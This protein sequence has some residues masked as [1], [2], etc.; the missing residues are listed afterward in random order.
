MLDIVKRF[1]KIAFREWTLFYTDSL[2]VLLLVVASLIYA[3]YYPL[4]YMKEI[5]EKV[6]AGI[7]DLDRTAFSRELIRMADATQDISVYKVYNTSEEARDDLA[8]EKIYGY[9]EIPKGYESEVR[10]GSNVTLG[11]YGHGAFLMLYRNVATA[12]STVALT[13]GA[14]VK[15]KRLVARG[16]SLAEAQAIRDPIPVR[17]YNMFNGING[18]GAYVVPAVLMLVLQQSL[19]IGISILG[20][21]RKNRHFKSLRGRDQHEDA[22]FFLRYFGRS[23]AYLV[24]YF[25][26][27]TIYHFGIYNIFGFPQRG[28][29][30]TLFAFGLAFFGAVVNMGMWTAQFFERRETGMQIFLCLSIPF[31]FMSGFSWPRSYM[32]EWIQILGAFIPTTYAIPA[33]LALENMG[34]SLKDVWH[35]IIDLYLLGGFYLILG[36]TIGKRHDFIRHVWEQRGSQRLAE[37]LKKFHPFS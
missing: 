34:A 11:V 1:F 31:L 12:F 8:G 18:Y 4:P 30:F 15:V 3:I 14:T 33:W 5:S 16:N 29:L 35:Y 25:S 20:G 26:F 32:P 17:F 24:H 13:Q 23:A 22:P 19:L 9:M 10:K 7:V 21:P 27:I 28:D 37:H 36:L 6:P 2:A